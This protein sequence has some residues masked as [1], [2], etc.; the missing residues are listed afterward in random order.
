[1]KEAVFQL[2]M[3]Q[4]DPPATAASLRALGDRLAN[5]LASAVPALASMERLLRLPRVRLV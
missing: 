3:A 5:G 2:T 1:V 4:L